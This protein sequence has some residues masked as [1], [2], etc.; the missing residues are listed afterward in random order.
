M[1]LSVLAPVDNAL[2]NNK[3]TLCCLCEKHLCFP[4]MLV[5]MQTNLWFYDNSNLFN[6]K[7]ENCNI[8]VLLIFY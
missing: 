8:F 6:G 1:A 4:S 5:P 2:K 7:R 3:Y